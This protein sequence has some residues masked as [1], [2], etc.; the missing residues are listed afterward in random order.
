MAAIFADL[1]AVGFWATGGTGGA[2]LAAGFGAGFRLHENGGGHQEKGNDGEGTN[3]FHK[4]VFSQWKGSVN[5]LVGLYRDW[6]TDRKS[7][8]LNS[9]HRL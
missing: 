7:T 8:R 5:A 3:E 6:E 4:F 2:A 9:S 1:I